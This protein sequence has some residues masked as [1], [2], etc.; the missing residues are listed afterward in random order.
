MEVKHALPNGECCSIDD[1]ERA[2]LRYY[3]G[4]PPIRTSSGERLILSIYLCR[5]F[6]IET[7]ATEAHFAGAAATII[8]TSLQL[9]GPGDL[10]SVIMGIGKLVWLLPEPIRHGRRTVEPKM[11]PGRAGSYL[12]RDTSSAFQRVC[13]DIMQIACGKGANE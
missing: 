11:R 13:R 4:P 7:A 10:E 2:V 1:I 9:R 8:A 12:T 3:A 6:D 5:L